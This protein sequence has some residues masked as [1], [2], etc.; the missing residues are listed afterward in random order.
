MLVKQQTHQLLL[1]SRTRRTAHQKRAGNP[2]TFYNGSEHLT[3]AHARWAAVNINTWAERKHRQQK[4]P[5]PWRLA[6]IEVL[7]PFFYIHLMNN[8][9]SWSPYGYN[10]DLGVLKWRKATPAAGS[11]LSRGSSSSSVLLVVSSSFLPLLHFT[12]NLLPNTG[13]SSLAVLV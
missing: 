1:V 6:Y 10:I 11:Q 13:C 2:T 3:S 5:Q 8:N 4:E 12:T 9:M 7:S